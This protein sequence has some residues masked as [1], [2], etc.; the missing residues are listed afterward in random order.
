MLFFSNTYFAFKVKSRL[1]KGEIKDLISSYNEDN[2][3]EYPL[4]TI[5]IS[6]SDGNISKINNCIQAVINQYYVRWELIIVNQGNIVTNDYIKKNIQRDTRIKL[7]NLSA[8][9]RNNFILDKEILNGEYTVLFGCTGWL[10]KDALDSIAR[11]IKRYPDTDMIYCD[12][13]HLDKFGLRSDPLFYPEYSPELF[14]QIFYKLDIL[15]YRTELLYGLD[16]YNWNKCKFYEKALHVSE[17]AKV[18]SHIPRILFHKIKKSY[19]SIGMSD[20]EN[21]K[22]SIEV[23]K[24]VIKRRNINSEIFIDDENYNLIRRT[25]SLKPTVSIIIPIRDKI[26]L[27][28]KLL[29]GFYEY[30]TYSNYQIIIIN[31]GSIEKRTKKY[32]SEITKNDS[33]VSVINHDKPFNYAEMMNI[34]VKTAAGELILFLNNDTEI[35]HK[36]WMEPMISYVCEDNI[37]AVGALLFY[38]DMSIQ[39]IGVGI[40][41]Q[42]GVSHILISK[43]MNQLNSSSRGQIF[44]FDRE[45]SAVTGACLMIRKNVYEE[46]GGMDDINFK[47]TYNDIDLCMKLREKKYRVI[48]TTSSRLIHHGCKSRGHWEDLSER[49]FFREKWNLA[50]FVDPYINLNYSKL[51]ESLAFG[52]PWK[53]PGDGRLPFTGF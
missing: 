10:E 6:I 36:Y 38:P 42:T 50:S 35:I 9:N 4:L 12:E 33:K 1:D 23:I 20:L 16:I 7:I 11:V 19:K 24:S 37:G 31:N 45:V 51:S 52:D 47:V 29:H 43:K 17:N 53:L 8:L 44:L 3:G 13:D 2:L 30:Q 27:L 32:L 28:E 21:D 22:D 25:L 46:I 14:L 34:G 15:V 5:I 18:I 26:E 39:H 40:G 49:K 48:L 41:F